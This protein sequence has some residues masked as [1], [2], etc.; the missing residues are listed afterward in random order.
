LPKINVCDIK[1][2]LR[3]RDTK[4][5]GKHSDKNK[6]MEA[7]IANIHKSKETLHRHAVKFVEQRNREGFKEDKTYQRPS[8]GC[9]FFG[10][11][12]EKHWRW[13]KQVNNE[14]RNLHVLTRHGA[15]WCIS[16]VQV[17][18]HLH[19]SRWTEDRA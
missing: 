9:S 2:V 8:V 13:R 10:F 16:L 12:E 11:R 18:A 7:N 1:V 3:T 5:Q 4:K 14:A 17:R 6:T 15:D 19:Q